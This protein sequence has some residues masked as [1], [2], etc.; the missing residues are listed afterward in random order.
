[1]HTVFWLNILV[2]GSKFRKATSEV[3]HLEHSF[4]SYWNLDTSG[5][6]SFL[7]EKFW[8]VVLEKDGEDQL[9]R[10]CEKWRVKEERN[11]LRAI[12]RRKN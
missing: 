5:N 11:I 1:M 3:L 6:R 4:I 10:S 7:P 2:G 9:D 8:N 12:K